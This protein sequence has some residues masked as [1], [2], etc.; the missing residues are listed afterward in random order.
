MKK[1]LRILL[2][3]F[4]IVFLTI[5]SISLYI[6]VKYS[7]WQKE[8][9]KGMQDQYT[10]SSSSIEQVDIE[11]KVTQFILS[12]ENT[13][14]LELEL[15][16][17]GSLLFNVLDYYIG[18]DVNLETMYIQPQRSKWVIYLQIKYMDISGWVGFDINKDNMQTAQ[19]YTTDIFVGP[20]SVKRYGNWVDMINKG[21]ADSIVTLNENGFVGRYLENIELLEDR[22]VIKGSRY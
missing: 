7:N 18:E 17:V 6:G 8:F 1:F 11:E 16:E 12:P 19:L 10:I 4:T 20:F 2:L 5:L 15:V 3:F 14:F 22:V 13:E 21:I 9:E